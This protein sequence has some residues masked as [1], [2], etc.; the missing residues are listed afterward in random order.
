MSEPS[1]GR[2]GILQRAFARLD[3]RSANALGFA[4]CAPGAPP[5]GP[6]DLVRKVFDPSYDYT[7]SPDTFTVTAFM[8]SPAAKLT[9]PVARVPEKSAALA[10]LPPLPVQ[11][12]W[13]SIWL[14]SQAPETIRM[15]VMLRTV[16]TP[17]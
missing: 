2:S 16:K 15:V 1:F 6:I 11:R 3:R 5:P 17:A 10:G 8:S 9:L 13:L 14:P 7:E 12:S 4:A